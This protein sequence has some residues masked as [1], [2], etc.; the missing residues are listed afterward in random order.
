[1]IGGTGKQKSGEQKMARSV[2][3][4]WDHELFADVWAEKGNPVKLCLLSSVLFCKID[5][6][7]FNKK[8]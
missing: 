4:E 3:Q 1:M 6:L 8:C 7:K 2:S 5:K